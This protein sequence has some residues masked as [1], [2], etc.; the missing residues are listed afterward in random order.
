MK[1]TSTSVVK[2]IFG[3]DNAFV[4][5]CALIYDL[6]L[7]NVLFVVTSLPIVTIGMAKRSLYQTLDERRGNPQLSVT[8]TYLSSFR[9]RKGLGLGLVELVTSGICI[10]NLMLL[11]GYTT[12]VVQAMKMLSIGMLLL[13]TMTF[14]MA[15]PL[16]TK[17]ELSLKELLI[18]AFLLAGK[19]LPTTLIAMA[20]ILVVLVILFSS[21]FAL[22]IGLS[23][24]ALGGYSALIYGHLTLLA[25]NK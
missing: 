14:L 12:P 2:T 25:N 19:Y 4:R 15:Y 1:K 17:A 6:V 21:G 5:T 24:L 11:R 3:L 10:A 7:L 20:V 9:S 16:G 13:I 18:Q 23:L 22:M 8:R